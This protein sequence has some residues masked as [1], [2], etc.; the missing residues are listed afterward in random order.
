MKR[1]ACGQCQK[2]GLVCDGY[3]QERV[4]VHVTQ[5]QQHDRY[6]NS[7]RHATAL[8]HTAGLVSSAYEERY[9]AVFWDAY[10]PH[11][12][13]ISSDVMGYTRGGWTNALPTLAQKSPIIRKILLAMCL[14]IAG[15]EW[16][17]QRERDESL[18]YFVSSLSDMSSALARPSGVD[19][20]ALSLS[21]RLYS[22]HEVHFPLFPSIPLSPP[23]LSPLP[24][25]QL[26]QAAHIPPVH[27]PMLTRF[28]DT[29]RPRRA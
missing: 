7:D 3:N 8:T 22:L 2:L 24:Y 14:R 21:S 13:Y 29:L 1:P 16:N 25:R 15:H 5:Q 10:L 12:R 9:L 17:Q 23:S 4:F 26:P 20:L 27:R 6:A 18:R 11:G 19:H 28:L